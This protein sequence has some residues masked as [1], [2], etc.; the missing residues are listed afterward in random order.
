M[1]SAA[2]R[3]ENGREERTGYLEHTGALFP[4][5]QINSPFLYLIRPRAWLSCQEVTYP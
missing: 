3:C 1:P 4:E 2:Q 5:K